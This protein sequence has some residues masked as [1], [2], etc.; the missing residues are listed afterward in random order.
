MR[1]C[2]GGEG[3]EQPAEFLPERPGVPDISGVPDRY[4]SLR[5]PPKPGAPALRLPSLPPCR[6]VRSG[7]GPRCGRRSI[8]G[9][10]VCP[11][12]ACGAG[13]LVCS[14]GLGQP[15]PLSPGRARGL[16]P[17]RGCSG[18]LPWQ[19]PGQWRAP[20]GEAVPHCPGRA[21]PAGHGSCP[22]AV[23]SLTVCHSWITGPQD[24]RCE[25][26]LLSQVVLKSN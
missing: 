19:C 1:C 24:T 15:R 5:V 4:R 16:P 26:Y 8:P 25:M 6:A 3:R 12:G 22:R 18:T 17:S 2:W 21:L 20:A 7:A 11:P 10:P 9:P 13:G 14:L 23:A